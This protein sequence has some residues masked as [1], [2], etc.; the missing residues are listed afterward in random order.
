MSTVQR[1]TFR[2]R[3]AEE[4]PTLVVDFLS[5]LLPANSGNVQ[6][7]LLQQLFSVPPN[8]QCFLFSVIH[9]DDSSGIQMNH[10]K[11]L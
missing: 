1:R 4:F 7:S 11:T 10:R 3:T 8:M 5:D 9:L 6:M 2:F